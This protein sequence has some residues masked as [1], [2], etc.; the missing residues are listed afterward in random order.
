MAA[1]SS[2]SFDNF[3][4]ELKQVEAKDAVLTP[5]QQIDRLLKPGYTY[6]N[7]NPFEVLQ[8]DPDLSLD[9]IKKKFRRLSILVHPDKNPNDQE[10]AQTAFD[11]IKRAWSTL[12][13]K[14]TRK[15][16][17]EVV[18][19]ARGRTKMNMEEKRRRLKKEGKSYALDED[20]PVK[21]KI[22]VNILTMKLFADLERKRQQSEDKISADAKKKREKEIEDEEKK[23][24][25]KEFE[26]N[27]EESRQGRVDSWMSF[28]KQHGVAKP[29]EPGFKAKKE[30]KEKKAKKFSP[31]GF[32]PPKTKPESR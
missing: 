18:E 7:L 23:N 13:D 10:R 32:R 15:A 21:F 11:A 16:A 5:K 20:D 3:Y 17:M 26:K 4:Q 1:G 24:M 25:I 8:V 22:A 2:S 27:W 19:E 12:E 14:E 29:P 6:R 9:E 31:I 30:K 28:T